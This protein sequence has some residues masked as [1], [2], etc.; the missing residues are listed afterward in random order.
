[1]PEETRE[2]TLVSVGRAASTNSLHAPMAAEVA[3]GLLLPARAGAF[4][5][6][7]SGLTRGQRPSQAGRAPSVRFIAALTGAGVL[8]YYHAPIRSPSLWHGSP[9]RATPRAWFDRP[10]VNLASGRGRVLWSVHLEGPAT[11]GGW[12]AP[13]GRDRLRW[14]LREAAGNRTACRVER[15]ADRQLPEA[16]AAG[17]CGHMQITRPTQSS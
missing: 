8:G 17:V 10:A 15:P 9:D 1:M 7:A 6:T 2:G 12:R 14:E 3:R 5:V 13:S 4:R 11:I 16:R